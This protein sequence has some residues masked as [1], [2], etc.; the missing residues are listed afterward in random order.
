MKKIGFISMVVLMAVCLSSCSSRRA[1]VSGGSNGSG[2]THVSIK[3]KCAVLDFQAGTNVTAEE[4]EAI[5]YNFRTGFY[6]SG[7]KIIETA[8]VDK[9]VET[10]GYSKTS[11]TKEQL[12]EVGR[13]LEANMVVVGTVNKLMDEYSVDVQVVNVS[14]GTT[15]ASQGD[16]FQKSNYRAGAKSIAQKL[17]NKL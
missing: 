1:E 9:V 7:Y 12:C 6:P 14:K 10:L 17:A 15:E 13:N 8:R 3:G 5:T 16:T 2:R 4:V 11:M